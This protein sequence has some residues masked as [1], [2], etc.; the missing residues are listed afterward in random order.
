MDYLNLIQIL[1]KD[2]NIS[3]IEFDLIFNPL[4]H[5]QSLLHHRQ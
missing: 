2:L 5:K 4:R 3:N 1:K